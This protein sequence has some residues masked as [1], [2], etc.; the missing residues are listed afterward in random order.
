[1]SLSESSEDETELQTPRFVRRSS[2]FSMRSCT[3]GRAD[4]NGRKITVSIKL[5]LWNVQTVKQASEYFSIIQRHPIVC[6]K[7]GRVRANFWRGA[8]HMESASRS[9]PSWPELGCDSERVR[10]N[11]SR[12]RKIVRTIARLSQKWNNTLVCITFNYDFF[13]F[14]FHQPNL[15]YTNGRDFGSQ[16]VGKHSE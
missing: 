3:P 7:F 14:F 5:K 16:H 12:R 13:F 8:S 10:E 4:N 1:M 11:V 15:E 9:Y 6:R 2:R